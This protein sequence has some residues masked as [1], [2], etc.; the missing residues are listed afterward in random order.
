MSG[1]RSIKVPESYIPL[2]SGRIIGR[3]KRGDEGGGYLKSNNP[4]ISLVRLGDIN[5]VKGRF[6]ERP[7]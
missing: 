2:L 1:W 5:M 4:I 7:L 6:L 3:F